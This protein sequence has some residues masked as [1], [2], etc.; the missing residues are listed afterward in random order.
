M[1]IIGPYIV[2]RGTI[3]GISFW[4]LGLSLNNILDKMVK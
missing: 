3:S 1:G 2:A 4:K